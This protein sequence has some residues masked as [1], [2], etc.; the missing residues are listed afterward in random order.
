MSI[1]DF[2]MVKGWEAFR[3]IETSVVEDVARN[4]RSIIDTGGGVI[5]RERNMQSLKAGGMV[6][7]LNADANVLS[8]RIKNEDTRPSLKGGVEA[9]E[10]VNEVLQE[11]LPLYKRYADYI[12]DT[13]KK[14]PLE[15]AE[16]ILNIFK[17]YK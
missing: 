10:E 1:K 16:E 5:L 13:T 4:D 14:T 2:V 12:I 3:D 6:F 17:R 9:W 7:F 8:K 15:V 11:R